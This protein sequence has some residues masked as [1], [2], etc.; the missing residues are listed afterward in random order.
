MMS[1]LLAFAALD[2]LIATQCRVLTLRRFEQMVKIGVHDFERTAPQR[3]WFD[4]DLCVKLSNAAAAQD[5]IAHTLN[6]DFVRK[7][8][9]DVIGQRH[10]ELQETLCDSIADLLMANAVVHGVRVLTR[11]PDVYP[12]CDSIGVERVLLKPW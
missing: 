3:M 6:Y 9:V 4:V 12:D 10:H 11:K 1:P 7:V 8:I 5:D 2:P